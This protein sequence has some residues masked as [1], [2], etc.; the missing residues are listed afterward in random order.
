MNIDYKEHADKVQRAVAG[1]HDLVWAA[2]QYGCERCRVIEWIYMGVGVEGPPELR[3]EGN[4]IASPMQGPACQWC[5][6]ET[7]HIN[8]HRDQEFPPKPVPSGQ[9]YFAVPPAWTEE[10]MSRYSS[11]VFS[12]DT[13]RAP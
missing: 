12:G 9:R 7:S 10:H 11:V 4:Y 5:G 2:F 6:G 3:N 8:W 1:R 13:K